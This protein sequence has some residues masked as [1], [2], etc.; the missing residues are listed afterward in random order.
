VTTIETHGDTRDE[1]KHKRAVGRC[2]ECAHWRTTDP[3]A[4]RAKC[5]ARKAITSYDSSCNGLF[6]PRTGKT[7]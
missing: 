3:W 7:P 6:T 1:P 5:A 2:S 4:S